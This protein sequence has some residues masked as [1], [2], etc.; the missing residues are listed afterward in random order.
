[1]TQ[2]TVQATLT[3]DASPLVRAAKTGQQAINDLGDT[4]N[5]AGEKG[6]SGFST[7]VGIIGKVG[8]AA[9]AAG[10]L[11]G[12]IV[13]GTAIQKGVQRLAA[14]Q[15][16]TGALT[17][18]LGDA[19][20]AADLTAKALATVQG[21]PFAFPQ[22][23]TATQQLVS[24][25]VKATVIPSLLTAIADAAASTGGGSSAVDQLTYSFAKMNSVGKLTGETINSFAVGGVNAVGILANAL[26]VT[27]M[28]ARDL[29]SKGLVPADQ[30]TQILLN[31]IENGSKGAAGVFP[32]MAGAAKDMGQSLSGS[33]DNLT[34]AFARMGA[35]ALTPFQTL[36]PL[37]INGGLIPVLDSAGKIVGGLMQK[38]SDTGIIQGIITK[39]NEF[40]TALTQFQQGAGP[41]VPIVQGIKAAFAPWISIVS[42][43]VAVMPQ[44]AP[45]FAALGA[46]IAYIYPQVVV[47]ATALGKGLTGA[48]TTLAPIVTGLFTFISGHMKL[49]EGVALG[50]LAAVVAFKVLSGVTLVLDGV[51][52][53][54]TAA[55]VLFTTTSK[56]VTSATKAWAAAQLLLSTAMDA[57][58]IGLIVIAIAALVAG[59][60]WIATQTTFFQD[61]W[62]NMVTAISTAWNWL[63]TT[64]LKPTFDAIAAVFIWLYNTIIAPQ[65]ALMVGIFQVLGAIFTW[66]W[67][68]I[69]RPIFSLI[70]LAWGIMV[71]GA[72]ALWAAIQPVFQGIGDIINW[73]YQNVILPQV[74][75][76]ATV[77]K[78]FGD[79]VIG[80]TAL[81]IQTALQVIGDIFSWLNDNIV[82]PQ[83]KA[84]ATVFKWLHD[85]VIKPISDLI[86]T[87][88]QFIG[89]IWGK[90]FGGMG[91]T[92][93][94]TFSGVETFV[95]GILNHIIDS[96][97]GVIGGINDVAAKVGAL[98]GI[99]V[100]LDKF[101]HLATGGKINRSGYA[102]VGERGPEIVKLGK[103]DTVYPTG[104]GPAGEGGDHYDIKIDASGWSPDQAAELADMVV[105]K[106]RRAKG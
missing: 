81:G 27:T 104:T 65:V 46:I 20:Q 33:L 6:R 2:L 10:A 55:T 29:V 44:L 80:P 32:K 78:W 52:K 8:A 99:K 9:T 68:S 15:D 88:V 56:I 90:V 106:I 39:F 50:V 94:G 35:N 42:G 63:W 92:V 26:G 16:A 24:F 49:F 1:M 51:T 48:I 4:A 97:N 84:I 58:P 98:T 93:K 71:V 22:F 79:T 23:A 59:I 61:A 28:E 36:I 82:Q 7:V 76:M 47:I 105:E 54:L 13:G 95:K 89:D 37:A 19:T 96:V 83:V 11:V 3:G 87:G 41:L 14:I 34:T 38:L 70:A 57:N 74:N 12:G 66:L 86:A 5:K 75:A 69:I 43:I 67:D 103:G 25:G 77:F 21:T 53:G 40:A 102:V 101:P 64:V 100:H 31:G 30:A 91:S 18:M 17:V 62:A 72:Q 73:L 60:I 45:I 85:S